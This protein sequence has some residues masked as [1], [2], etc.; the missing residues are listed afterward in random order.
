MAAHGLWQ[1][2]RLI[3]PHWKF[4]LPSKIDPFKTGGADMP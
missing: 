2:P 1:Q 3:L 4:E